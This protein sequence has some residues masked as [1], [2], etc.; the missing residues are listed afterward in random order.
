MRF[1]ASTTEFYVDGVPEYVG[2]GGSPSNDDDA[3][4][5]RGDK[6]ESIRAWGLRVASEVK[7]NG[8][9]DKRREGKRAERKEKSS[10]GFSGRS[11]LKYILCL[12][13]RSSQ[14]LLFPTGSSVALGRCLRGLTVRVSG[15]R[16]PDG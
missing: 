15:R 16:S 9:I 1:A 3:D 4:D 6:R 5:V 11:P 13:L 14:R 8:L 2:L 12:Q 10:G 7:D